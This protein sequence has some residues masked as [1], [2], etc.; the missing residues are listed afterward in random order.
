ML[1]SGG[2]APEFSLKDFN[3]E[4]LSLRDFQQTGPVLVVF[5][6]ISCPTC[7]LTLPFLQR[8]N[9]SIPVI[10][11]SED[12]PEATREFCEY[13]KI[14]FPVVIDPA[15]D[16]YATSSA[17]RLTNVPSTFLIEKDGRISWSLNGF[18]KSELAKMAEMVGAVLFHPED[19]VP[20]MKPG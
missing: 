12:D 16:R 6:K 7:Q 20:A 4:R 15:K 1:E 13:F 11:V 10:G 9:E 14:G 18:D 17:Y 8:L 2:M 19:K 3:G 5:F